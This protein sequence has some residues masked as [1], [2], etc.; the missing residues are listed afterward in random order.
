MSLWGQSNTL[1][2]DGFSN[3][4]YTNPNQKYDDTGAIVP[5]TQNPTLKPP[6]FV[7][8]ES[9][10]RNQTTYPDAASFEI[11]LPSMLNGV[12]S[13]EVVSLTVPRV[14]AGGVAPVDPY[15][16][17]FNGLLSTNRP[18]SPALGRMFTVPSQ[19]V[20]VGAQGSVANNCFGQ[21]VYDSSSPVQSFLRRGWRQVTYHT[22][23]LS[24]VNKIQ[25]A[26]RY[27]T[28]AAYDLS[29]GLG[30]YTNWTCVL[31]VQTR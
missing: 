28:G 26:L 9:A 30:G 10:F 14:R 4:P 17:L 31:M 18:Q 2:V 13:V 11:Q 8:I 7:C 5:F 16:Y 23:E 20:L 19:T 3:D 29:D 12:S 6:V 21:F 27:S 15:F 22:T 1:P 25:V 24:G